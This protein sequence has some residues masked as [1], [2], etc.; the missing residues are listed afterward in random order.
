[1]CPMDKATGSA[2]DDI[3]VL[4]DRS[5]L[6]GKLSPEEKKKFLLAEPVINMRPGQTLFRQGE[7]VSHFYLVLSGLIKLYRVSPD[8]TEQV[9]GLMEPGQ[10]FAEAA[11]FMRHKGYPVN[12]T[13]IEP[14]Q[15]CAL[16]SRSFMEH[17]QSHP[18]VCMDMLGSV[19]Q[20]LHARVNEL[21]RIRLRNAEHRLAWYLLDRLEDSEAANGRI[22]LPASQVTLASQLAMMPETLSRAIAR[23]INAD[24]LKKDGKAFVVT[25]PAALRALL[26][27]DSSLNATE[28]P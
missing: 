10:T 26:A 27:H 12:A 24:L 19:C 18:D 17:L 8:G 25:D 1:M 13:S 28:Q 16:E 3:F 4:A 11:M 23:L 15:L 14:S 5:A 7:F 9:I 6:L 20:R 21:S 22:T 2:T